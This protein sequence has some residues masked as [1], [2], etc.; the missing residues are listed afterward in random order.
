LLLGW[1]ASSKRNVSKYAALY[2]AMGYNTVSTTAPPSVVFSMSHDESQPF[3][4]SILR[5]LAA[6]PRLLA[7]GLVIHAYSSGGAIILPRLDMLFRAAGLGPSPGLVDGIVALPASVPSGLFGPTPQPALHPEDMPVVTAVYH[8]MAGIV[9][10]SCPCYMHPVT[11]A[12]CLI[13]GFD[14]PPNSFGARLFR[15]GF[16]TLVRLQFLLYGNVPARFWDGVT[17]AHYPC[18]ELYLYSTADVLLDYERVDALVEMRRK[19]RH[20]RTDA[21]AIDDE[22]DQMIRVWRVEDAPHVMLLRTHPTRYVAELRTLNNWAVNRLRKTIE[23]PG[24]IL[25]GTIDS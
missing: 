6:D 19:L 24:W 2:R 4:L 16:Y 13:S 10:D 8:A 12:D 23:I 9:F 1:F 3:L 21:T 11:G 7:G 22:N 15:A 20:S 14:L 18:P 5:A 25:P 17:N